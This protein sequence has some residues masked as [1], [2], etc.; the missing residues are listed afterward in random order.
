MAALLLCL[1]LL[2]GC[3]QNAANT[4]ASGSESEIEDGELAFTQDDF[5]ADYDALWAS[6]EEDYLYLPL[7]EARGIDLETLKTATRQQL[8][9]R[10]TDLDGFI[11]LL[12]Q[13]FGQMQNFAHLGVVSLAAYD[14]YQQYYTSPDAPSSGWQRALQTQQTQALYAALAEEEQ[15]NSS[16]VAQTLPQVE[17]HYDPERKALTLVLSS[18]DPT[19]LER[20]ADLLERTLDELGEVE[21]DHIIFDLSGNTGGTD[22]YWSQNLVAPFGGRYSWTDWWYLRDTPLTRSYFFADFDVESV[23]DLAGHTVPDFVQSL[24]LTHVIQV[25]RTL[26]AT[27]TLPDAIQSARRWVIVDAA[28]YSSADSFAA[29]CKQTGWATLVGQT[30]LGDGQG[31]SPLLIALPNTGLLVRFS[32]VAAETPEG[33]LNAETGTVPDYVINPARERNQDA[34]D[35]LIDAAHS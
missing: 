34:V 17:T 21:I 2:T 6:L 23:D 31:T 12:E 15:N 1:A 28:V 27:A 19:L 25:E 16:Q 5:L 10:V 30:T 18:F 9:A 20:D 24:S 4:P 13:L 32:G 29:F 26:D 11:A 33:N 35:R 7:L 3:A 14:A 22:L 8:E